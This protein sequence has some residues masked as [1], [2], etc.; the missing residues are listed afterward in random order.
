MDAEQRCRLALEFNQDRLA[1]LPNVVGL[2][3][4]EDTRDSSG[5]GPSYAVAVYV[6]RKVP[7][8]ELLGHEVVPRDIPVTAATAGVSVRTRIIESGSFQKEGGSHDGSEG[9]GKEAL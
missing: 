4:T 2:G 1:R 3:I 5:K 7:E 6:S 9:F 8:S